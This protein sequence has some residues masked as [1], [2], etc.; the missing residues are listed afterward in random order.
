MASPE[1]VLRAA[2]ALIEGYSVSVCW[3]VMPEDRRPL[4]FNFCNPDCQMCLTWVINSFGWIAVPFFNATFC[5][6]LDFPLHSFIF[7][8]FVFV[9]CDNCIFMKFMLIS[10]WFDLVRLVSCTARFPCSIL[11]ASDSAVLCV[12]PME[13]VDCETTLEYLWKL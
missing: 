12:S 11:C 9:M 2:G 5:H 1:M 4:F 7:Y 6:V 13:M 3:R 8:S 10:Q